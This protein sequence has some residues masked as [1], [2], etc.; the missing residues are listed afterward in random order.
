MVLC[1]LRLL[2]CGAIGEDYPLLLTPRGRREPVIVFLYN[3]TSCWAVGLDAFFMNVG[4]FHK[5]AND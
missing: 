3:P 5:N 4:N 2:R 1:G